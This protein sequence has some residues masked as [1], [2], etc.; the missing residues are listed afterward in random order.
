MDRL[1]E[2][3]TDRG[4]LVWGTDHSGLSVDQSVGW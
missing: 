2:I 3:Y 4:D 1:G